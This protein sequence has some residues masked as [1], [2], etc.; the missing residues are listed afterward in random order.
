MTPEQTLKSIPVNAVVYGYLK[1]D[2][3]IAA[4]FCAD[5]K[6]IKEAIQSYEIFIVK[7]C[8]EISNERLLTLIK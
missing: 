8:R 1:L 2:G 3:K 7:Q 6:E 5:Q 4:T